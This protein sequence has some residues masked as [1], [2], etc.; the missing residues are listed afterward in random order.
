MCFYYDNIINTY[1]KPKVTLYVYIVLSIDA[2]SFIS[3]YA[4]KYMYKYVN[5]FPTLLFKMGP[6]QII[7]CRYYYYTNRGQY[8]IS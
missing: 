6:P 1:H 2:M 5:G 7:L 3:Y 4:S 8:Y